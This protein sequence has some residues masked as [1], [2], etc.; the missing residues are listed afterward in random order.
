MRAAVDAL[1]R[2]VDELG[3]AADGGD[4]TDHAIDTRCAELA[5]GALVAGIERRLND[6]VPMRQPGGACL[7]RHRRR[8][9]ARKSAFGGTKVHGHPRQTVIDG[10]LEALKTPRAAVNALIATGEERFETVR[11]DEAIYATG[12]DGSVVVTASEDEKMSVVT[13]R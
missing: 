5:E 3:L 9:W 13:E 7:R 8:L 12:W 4:V 11:L 6:H 2:R 10:L 1:G